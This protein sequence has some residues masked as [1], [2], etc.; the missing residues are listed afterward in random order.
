MY[1]STFGTYDFLRNCLFRARA[2]A[3]V[4]K[5][6][7]M[8]HFGSTSFATAENAERGPPKADRVKF[9]IETAIL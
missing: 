1:E 2:F 4:T 3:G 9:C 7:E 6:S 5:T 8:S